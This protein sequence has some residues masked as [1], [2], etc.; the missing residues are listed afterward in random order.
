MTLLGTIIVAGVAINGLFAARNK[1]VDVVDI[2]AKRMH[3]V[4]QFADHQRVVVMSVLETVARED[5]ASLKKHH[6]IYQNK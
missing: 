2:Y 1:L 4:N 5:E 6:E 3:Y